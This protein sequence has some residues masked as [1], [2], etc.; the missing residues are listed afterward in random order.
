MQKALYYPHTRIQSEIM[1]KNALLLWDEIETIVPTKQWSPGLLPEES[2]T[3]REGSELVVRHR[4]PSTRERAAA[5]EVLS[6]MVREHVFDKLILRRL[7]AGKRQRFFDRNQYLIYPDKFLEKTWHLL[8]SHGLASWVSRMSDYAVPIEVGL[9]MMSILADQCAGTKIRK[10]TDRV[11][12]YD[13]LATTHASLLGADQITGFD[14]N[15]IAPTHDRLVTISLNVLDARKIPLSK[16]I[17]MRKREAKSGGSDY[18]LMR[19]RYLA[20]LDSH[21]E[22][23]TTK[24]KSKADVEEMERVFMET[25]KADVDQMKIELR[26]NAKSTL[27]SKEVGISALI[28]GGSF[29]IPLA[30]FASA[31]IG[32][33]IPLVKAAS[34]YGGKRREILQKHVMSWLYTTTRGRITLY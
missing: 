25:I 27:F 20:A 23:V 2:R 19:R 28:A 11:D 9:Y 3:F 16:L 17:D 22:T 18:S 5:H 4:I 12:A 10:I 33:V 30:G 13:W 26:A 6:Q 34:D 1:L 15:E 21:L 7:H 14:V 24:A 31:G 29:A 32:G 8:Q